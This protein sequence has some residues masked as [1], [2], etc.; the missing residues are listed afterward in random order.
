MLSSEYEKF[1]EYCPKFSMSTIIKRHWSQLFHIFVPA[2]PANILTSV[3][4]F[5]PV[6]FDSRAKVPP[7]KRYEKGYGNENGLGK[8]GRIVLA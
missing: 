2:I 3:Q 4:D 1:G 8:S 5:F 7:A 6:P